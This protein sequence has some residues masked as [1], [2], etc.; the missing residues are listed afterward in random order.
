MRFL[1]SLSLLGLIPALTNAQEK[2]PK[3]VQPIAVVELKRAEPVLYDKDIEPIF[4]NKCAVCH[5]DNIN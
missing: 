4:V 2:K 1:L 3:L 5:S